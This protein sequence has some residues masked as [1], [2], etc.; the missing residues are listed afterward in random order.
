MPLFP[1]EGR[2]EGAFVAT[3]GTA[4][5]RR[6]AF[7]PGPHPAPGPG[8]TQR[9][10]LWRRLVT[11]AAIAGP[12]LIAANAGNDAG[13]IATYASAGSQFRYRALFIMVLITIGLVVV[14]EMSARLGAFTGK[15]LAALIREEFSIRLAFLALSALLVANVGIVVSEFAGIGAA[16]ELFGVSRYISVPV[17]AVT[18]WVLVLFGSYRYAERV[19]LLLSLAF[20][21]YPI[22]AVLGHP[23][24][25]AVAAAT[26]LPHFVASKAFI[27]LGVALIGTTISPYMQLYNAAAVVDRGIGSAEYPVERVDT[28]AGAIFADLISWFI[29]VATAGALGGSGVLNSAKEAAQ[30]LRPVAGPAAEVLFGLGLL[31]ASAL[32][33]AV[34]PLSTSYALAEAIGVERSVSRSFREA[35]LFLGLFSAQVLIGAL[36]ALV[37]VN[38]ITLLIGTQVLQGVVTPVTLVFIL[39]LANRRSVL[40]EHANGPI[41]K[42]VAAVAVAL[43][44]L[45]AAALVV[46]TVAGLF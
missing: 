34:V 41:F 21:S 3:A 18:I 36:V 26:V 39:V 16:F 38:L 6:T 10:P 20:L 1:A 4:P 14:Q 33:G 29:I 42:A 35:P 44:A 31:G 43:V 28:V 5:A 46:I 11:I 40:G 37:P 17:A 30:A 7:A 19:F 13:G 8:S 27:L 24:W 9:R 15:G 32:A 12:G 25:K 22:A 23:D 2:Q 45:M